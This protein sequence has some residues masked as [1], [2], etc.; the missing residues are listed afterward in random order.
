MK[1]LA[2]IKAHFFA[3]LEADHGVWQILR[4]PAIIDNIILHAVK[5]Q[6]SQDPKELMEIAN[7]SLKVKVR[8]HLASIKLADSIDDVLKQLESGA[9]LKLVRDA[10]NYVFGEAEHTL[11]AY[12]KFGKNDLLNEVEYLKLV[13]QLKIAPFSDEVFNKLTGISIALYINT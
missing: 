1:S 2:S 10:Y 9:R 11:H 6:K 5:Y 3:E 13:K 7:L 4:M 8:Q 12:Y